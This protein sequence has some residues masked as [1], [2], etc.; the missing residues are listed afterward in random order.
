M[1]F[2]EQCL[3]DL[4]CGPFSGGVVSCV[5]VDDSSLLVMQNDES[6]EHAKSGGWDDEEVARDRFM[7]VIS[8]KRVPS[9]R[10]AVLWLDSVFVDCRFGD[11]LAKKLELGL[12]SRRSPRR[13]LAGHAVNERDDFAVDLRSAWFLRLPSPVVLE[14]LAV[15]PDDGRRLG[16]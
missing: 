15:P 5:E 8:K 1:V 11:L 14:T 4:D 2:V 16:V 10:R 13:I 12:N 3:L 6:E 7:H 9:L